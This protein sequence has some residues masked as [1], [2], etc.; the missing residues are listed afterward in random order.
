MAKMFSNGTEYMLFLET[1][2][3]NC[4]KYVDWEIATKDNP[5][6]PIEEKLSICNITGEEEYWPEEIQMHWK[7]INDF[8]VPVWA[9][10]EFERRQKHDKRRNPQPEARQGA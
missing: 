6:C 8:K 10:S 9:C 2:C 5:V 3:L 4:K 7:E 1:V